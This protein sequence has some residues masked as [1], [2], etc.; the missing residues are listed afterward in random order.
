M[1]GGAH[2]AEAILTI[3]LDA[4]ASNYRLLQARMGGKPVAPMVKADAYGLGVHRVAPTL[5]REGARLFFVAQ[6]SEAIEL[7]EIL[8][9][10]AEIA[11]LNGLFA[12]EEPVFAE[13][14]TMVGP[15]MSM[16]SM[17]VGR[18]APADVTAS[19]G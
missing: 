12:G 16:F 5:W 9:A 15:P 19:K 18:S 10:E 13:A 3:D 4:I 8:P 6:L 17:A 11:V 1:P 14:R 2:G 7:R